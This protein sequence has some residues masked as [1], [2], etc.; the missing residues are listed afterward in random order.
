MR[1]FDRPQEDIGADKAVL[2]CESNIPYYIDL[3]LRIGGGKGTSHVHRL[4]EWR[5]TPL[6]PPT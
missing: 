4:S 2:N 6:T 3:D 5:L 1:P